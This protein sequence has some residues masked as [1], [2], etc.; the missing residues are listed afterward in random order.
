MTQ[1]ELKL[2][3]PTPRV[4]TTSSTLR[5]PS[6]P[7]RPLCPNLESNASRGPRPTTEH[8]KSDRPRRKWLATQGE[9]I[10]KGK[11]IRSQNWEKRRGQ[12]NETIRLEPRTIRSTRHE[13]M[14][15]GGAANV[16]GKARCRRR[17]PEGT[18][19]D[20]KPAVSRILWNRH[21]YHQLRTQPFEQNSSMPSCRMG[22]H[23]GVPQRICLTKG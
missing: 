3:R 4:A 10:Q 15:A 8:G 12:I 16:V 14:R 5:N 2:H 17:S 23:Q 7:G 20:L 22:K 21:R 19:R 13:R 6:C 1:L 11:E 9:E 18:S